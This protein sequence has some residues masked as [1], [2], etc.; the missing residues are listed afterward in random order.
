[1]TIELERAY[2]FSYKSVPHILKFLN[3]KT[4]GNPYNIVEKE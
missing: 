1:M 3:A 4:E 2:V